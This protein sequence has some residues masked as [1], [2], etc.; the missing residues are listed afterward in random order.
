MGGEKFASTHEAVRVVINFCRG[1]SRSFRAGSRRGC[2]CFSG[3]GR[4]VFSR[5]SLSSSCFSSSFE[6]QSG[7]PALLAVS[8]PRLRL[9]RQRL[10]TRLWP[11]FSEGGR[12][13]PRVAAAARLRREQVEGPVA[14]VCCWDRPGSGG[15]DEFGGAVAGGPPSCRQPRRGRDHGTVAGC[16][17][18]RFRGPFT[19][20]P[21]GRPGRRHCLLTAQGLCVCQRSAW[22]SPFFFFFF[23]R[24]LPLVFC[25]FDTNVWGDPPTLKSLPS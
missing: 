24:Q 6:S 3:G 4:L 8:V 19:P 16:S 22:F 20:W 21:A 10:A 9:L 23:W 2:R 7:R 11:Y 25:I 12:V 14:G 13:A 5:F 18:A 17:A 1:L 15:G